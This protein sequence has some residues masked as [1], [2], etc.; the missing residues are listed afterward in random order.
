MF[1]ELAKEEDYHIVMIEKIYKQLSE[2][3]PLGEWITSTGSPGDLDKV[4][5]ESLKEE[6][7]ASSDDLSAL[8]FGLEREEKS[9]AYYEALARETGSN[10]EKRFYLTLSYEERG[11][12]L[13]IMDAMEFLTDPAGWYYV[14]EGSMVD[15]G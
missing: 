4:F 5:G 2:N 6:A 13:R 11:H 1:E 14:R 15:G 9:I 12:Y 3:K 10:R 8:R 7:R